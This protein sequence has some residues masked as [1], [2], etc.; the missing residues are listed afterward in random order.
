MDSRR[1]A[2]QRTADLIRANYTHWS[3]LIDVDALL[4]PDLGKFPVSRAMATWL[5][6]AIHGLDCRSI[7]EFGAGWSSLVIAEALAAEGGGRLTSV[8]HDPRYLPADAWTRIDRLTNVDTR[9][10]IAPLQRTLSRHGLL[11]SYRGVRKRIRERSPFD[12]VFIDGPPNRYGR[13]SPLFDAY[14]LLGPDAV[15]VLDDAARRDER[16]AIARWLAAYPDL[17]LVLLDTERGR[18]IAVLLRHGGAPGRPAIGTVQ[19]TV[20]EQVRRWLKSRRL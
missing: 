3:L 17:E 4:P 5:A 14:P 10:V 1:T 20:R 13:T 19:D 7:L 8:E 12:L 18:G 9:L 16:T 2:S 6:S 15:V 11:W